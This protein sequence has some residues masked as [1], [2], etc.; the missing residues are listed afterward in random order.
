MKLA[1]YLLSFQLYCWAIKYREKLVSF[2]KQITGKWEGRRSDA[3]S[4][5]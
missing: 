2:K 5:S 1:T 3:D 4:V